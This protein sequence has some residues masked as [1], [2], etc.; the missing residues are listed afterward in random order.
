MAEAPQ[1][2]SEETMLTTY[3][4]GFATLPTDFEG[5]LVFSPG[6]IVI[7]RSVALTNDTVIRT[8]GRILIE[9]DI[10]F[11]R[12]GPV[13][14]TLSAGEV[15]AMGASIGVA[16]LRIR[17]SKAGT[18][19]RDGFDGGDLRIFARRV[20]FLD[21]QGA[22]IPRRIHGQ[23]GGAGES[24]AVAQGNVGVYKAG[25]GGAGGTTF[26]CVKDLL[27]T[28]IRVS[29]GPGGGGGNAAIASPPGLVNVEGGHGG[30]GGGLHIEGWSAQPPATVDDLARTG[31]SYFGGGQGGAGGRADLK[32]RPTL[33]T[34]T[35]KGTSQ[36]GNGGGTAT[37]TS[38]NVVLG[39]PGMPPVVVDIGMGGDGGDAVVDLDA[40][41][42]FTEAR[43][44]GGHGGELGTVGAGESGTAEASVRFGGRAYALPGPLSSGLGSLLT[45]RAPCLQLT[46]VAYG[47]PR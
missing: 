2:N 28:E 43:A 32:P 5:G 12:D 11:E 6:D 38:R 44:Y 27:Q 10:L 4:D 29:G 22:L 41:T 30:D 15:R 18:V 21:G 13:N 26:I 46:C 7:R 8:S 9:A 24:L 20:S 33:A 14:L 47:E 45:R 31:S 39:V 35:S 34:S 16:P 19:G 37:L 42:A 36:G 25:N 17:G 40:G 23:R 1:P 3:L